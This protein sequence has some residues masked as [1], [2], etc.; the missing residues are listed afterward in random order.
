[1]AAAYIHSGSIELTHII[2][3]SFMEKLASTLPHHLPG[4]R[5]ICHLAYRSSWCWSPSRAAHITLRILFDPLRSLDIALWL[6]PSGWC[7]RLVLSRTSFPGLSL[8]GATGSSLA[9]FPTEPSLAVPLDP[10]RWLLRDHGQ[11]RPYP[12]LP[13]AWTYPRG[14]SS[15]L[16]AIPGITLKGPVGPNQKSKPCGLLKA[17]FLTTPFDP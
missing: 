7:R 15:V 16:L 17:H 6:Q 12:A 8:F 5:F 2:K 13:S 3:S 9:G 4:S 11:T 14:R 1:M 10:S